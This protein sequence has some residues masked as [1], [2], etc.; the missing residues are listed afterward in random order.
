MKIKYRRYYIYYCLKTLIFLISRIPRSISL[1]IAGSLGRAGFFALK[2]YRE[3]ALS[4]LDMVY[5]TS[6][7]EN[8]N[9]TKNMFINLAKNGA[10]WIKMFHVGRDYIRGLVTEV[11]GIQNLDQAIAKGNGVILLASHFGNWELLSIYLHVIGY[12]GVVLAKELYFYK[13]EKIISSMRKKF[14][15]NV[16]YRDRSPKDILKVLKTGGILGILADQDIDDVEGVFVDFFGRPAYTP[17][18]PVRLGLRTSAS[19]VPAFM[20]RKKDETYKLVL[21]EPFELVPGD[22][23]ADDIKKYTQKWTNVLEQYVR[24]YPEQWVWLH[25]RWKTGI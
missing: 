16:L 8:L 17:V 3:I 21:H 2:K 14:G 18:A 9:I 10:D 12:S 22:S 5:G 24:R 13:Y 20:I 25:S 7:E 4:N 1:F 23:R 6:R 11:D 15:T 19:L